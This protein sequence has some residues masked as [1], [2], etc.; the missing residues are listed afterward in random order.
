LR[1][2]VARD[3]LPAIRKSNKVQRVSATKPV[4]FVTV[5]S[6]ETHTIA[7]WSEKTGVPYSTI[8]RRI[9]NGVPSDQAV[10]LAP[11]IKKMKLT[12]K[13]IEVGGVRQSV[14]EW[15]KQCGVPRETIFYRLK[16]GWSPAQAVGLEDRPDRLWEWEGKRYTLLELVEMHGM[17]Y[18]TVWLRL[19]NGWSLKE[20]LTTPAGR[21]VKLGRKPKMTPE[22]LKEAEECLR[23]GLSLAE[24]AA[25]LGVHRTTLSSHMSSGM[26]AAF[27]EAK[28]KGGR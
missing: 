5:S 17:I 28:N 24:T 3:R 21:G 9:R 12:S 10:G 18:Q 22:K 11:F 19:R 15:S 25:A 16:S 8:R 26:T 2:S 20:A 23:S 1:A 6:G 14:A 13:K 27:A 7:K 4:K